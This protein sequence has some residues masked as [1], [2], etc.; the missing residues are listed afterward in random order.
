MLFNFQSDL[1]L[2]T[3]VNRSRMIQ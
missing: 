1:I 3:S 2:G